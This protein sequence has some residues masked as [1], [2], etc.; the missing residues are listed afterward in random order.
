MEEK[1]NEKIRF[2]LI[3][4]LVSFIAVGCSTSEKKSDASKNENT[5][6]KSI[7]STDTKNSS[8]TEK[9]TSEKNETKDENKSSDVSKDLSDKW[10]DNQIQINGKVLTMPISLSDFN[11]LGFKLDYSKEYVLNPGD[12]VAGTHL[13]NDKGNSISG[14]YSNLSDKVIDIKESSLTSINITNRT[15]KDLDVIFPGGIK[16]GNSVEDVKRIY[17]EPED[18]YDG[19]NGFYTLTYKKERTH[20]TILTFTEGKLSGYELYI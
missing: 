3:L 1:Y 2:Y 15:N 19:G 16:F 14:S 12:S 17:G 8:E 5:T 18:T 6:E 11:K 9:N 4:A 10:Y 7:E 13:I 20:Y